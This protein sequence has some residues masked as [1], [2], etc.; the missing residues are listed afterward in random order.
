MLPPD[1]P[2]E[3]SVTSDPVTGKKKGKGREGNGRGRRRGM[4]GEWNAIPSGHIDKNQTKDLKITSPN[5]RLR[6]L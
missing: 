4:E 1:I 5:V 2:T 6:S 3:G